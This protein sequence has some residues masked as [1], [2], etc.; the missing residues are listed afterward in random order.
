[1]IALIFDSVSGITQK[2]RVPKRKN[3]NQEIVLRSYLKISAAKL[4]RSEWISSG[5]ITFTKKGK[6]RFK[7]DAEKEYFEE[8]QERKNYLTITVR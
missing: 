4:V 1:M 5:K 3:L 7:D 8:V 6:I 2:Y